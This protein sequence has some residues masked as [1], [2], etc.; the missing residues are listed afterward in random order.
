MGIIHHF[1]EKSNGF[2]ETF[3]VEQEPAQQPQKMEKAKSR[4]K[5]KC[6]RNIPR[7]DQKTKRNIKKTPYENAAFFRGPKGAEGFI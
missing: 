6:E 1:S 4:K 7:P 2:V 5:F 3:L